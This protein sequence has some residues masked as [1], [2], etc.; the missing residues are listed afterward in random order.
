M[1][2]APLPSPDGDKRERSSRIYSTAKKVFFFL[3]VRGL[4][5]MIR[6]LWRGTPWDDVL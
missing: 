6:L 1:T 4:W 3:L 5:E 2:S